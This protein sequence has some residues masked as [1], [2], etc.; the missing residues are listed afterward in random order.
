VAKIVSSQRADSGYDDQTGEWYHFPHTYYRAAKE[1][2]GDGCIYYEP[3]RASGRLV[4]WA[5]A[6]I[7]EVTPDARRADHYY[8]RITEFLPF[9]SPV[10]FLREDGSYWESA[11]HR[12]DGYPSKGAMGRSVRRIPE[13]EFDLILRAG[14]APVLA[15]ELAPG[16][17]PL[18]PDQITYGSL[19]DEQL[20]YERPIIERLTARWF[21]DRVFS[22]NVRNAYESCCA[23]TGLRIIN[24]GGR[25]EMEAAHIKPVEHRGTDS[26][27]NGLALSR[28][29]HW[30]FDRGLI[31]VDN[32]FRLL[33]AARLLPDGVDR[34]F[35]PSGY[36]KIP[37]DER[38]RPNPAFLE[39]HRSNCFK[40]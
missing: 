31:S 33:T 36:I 5:S 8:A 37:D 2:E 21:R 11:L 17:R 7:A 15:D 3:R 4:Y 13:N 12:G 20:E 10:S 29:V 39:W 28:T 19:Q 35:H 30:M 23:V 22:T 38:L 26:V 32:D 25:A 9:P 27:R 34:L 40:G 16:S 6:R 1:A 24:G 18:Q 14:Y